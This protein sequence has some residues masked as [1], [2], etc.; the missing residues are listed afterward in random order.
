MSVPGSQ[1]TGS[2]RETLAQLNAA[3]LAD[4]R[5]DPGHVLQYVESWRRDRQ[6]ARRRDHSSTITFA[7]SPMVSF[8]LTDTLGITLIPIIISALP[9]KVP[10]ATLADLWCLAA[11]AGNYAKFV[12]RAPE[13]GEPDGT[14]VASLWFEMR[15]DL[16]LPDRT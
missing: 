11:Q 15:L 7:I 14:R 13:G 4:L 10:E 9:D 3:L 2:E 6:T 1:A 5:I 12:A 16:G 8:T